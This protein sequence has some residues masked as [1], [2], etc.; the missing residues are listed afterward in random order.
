MIFQKIDRILKNFR[1]CFSREAAFKWFVIVIIGLLVRCDHDGIS[2][3]IRW[4]SLDPKC[5]ETLCQFF[6]ASSWS[7]ACVSAQWTTWVARQFPL[8]RVNGRPVII[9]DG[10]KAGKEGKR[11][12]CVKSL[13]QA[14]T[15]NSKKSKIKGHHFGFVGVVT[16][17]LKKM[18]CT[19]LK[20]EIHEG[21][22]GF[23]PSEGLNGKPP[24]LISRMARLLVAKALELGEPCYAVL[25]AY[26]ATRT[27]FLIFQETLTKCGEPFV[28]LIVRAKKDAV[29][30][31]KKEGG[32]FLNKHKVK[33]MEIFDHPHMFKQAQVTTYGKTKT[34]SYCCL[35]LFWKPV[36]RLIRFVLVDDNGSH[37]I[38]MSS[39]LDLC[40]IDIIEIYSYRSKIEV[41]FD[42]LKNLLGGFAYRFW[43][44]LHPK[45]KVITSLSAAELA[46]NVWEK[47]ELTLTASERFVNL[48]AMALGILQYLS[49]TIAGDIWEKYSGWLRTYSSS[50]PSERVVQMVVKTEYFNTQRKVPNS[51][52]LRIIQ[53]KRKD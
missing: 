16:G 6:R 8:F 13:H 9:G 4:L 5:Y 19:P 40:P 45:G 32:K 42:M 30:F 25:D 27:P 43:S 50:Y 10:I 15:N 3:I 18:F 24:T 11:M 38:L 39:D 53:E 26:F 12:T 41:T 17:T 35:D 1:N 22:D 37:Y 46:P 28:H 14:S 49:L 48:A 21:V 36:D 34:I 20:G 52:T 44:K 51:R 33:L 7:L 29:A 23:R 2:S 47:L 31:L